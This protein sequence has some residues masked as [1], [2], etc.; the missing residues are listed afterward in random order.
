[1][2]MVLGSGHMVLKIVFDGVI[3]M[4]V[5]C[6][7]SLL[8]AEAGI[9]SVYKVCVW[10]SDYCKC[11]VFVKFV[12]DEVIIVSFCKVCVWRKRAL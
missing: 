3:I 10:G 5:Q 12:F 6:L 2:F 8:L 9:V 1:V 11:L 4:S 7:Q